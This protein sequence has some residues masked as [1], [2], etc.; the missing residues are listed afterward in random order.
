MGATSAQT[1]TS[2]RS[3]PAAAQGQQKPPGDHLLQLHLHIL[4]LHHHH[5]AP[6]SSHWV[7]LW[8]SDLHS[9]LMEEIRKGVSLKRVEVDVDVDVDE[10]KDV[11][12]GMYA[13]E[14]TTPGMLQGALLQR[15]LAVG[16]FTSGEL[17]EEENEWDDF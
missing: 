9:S 11:D 4:H 10:D 8:L 3:P 17:E 5:Q 14:A 16:M 13:V 1:E 15:R 6:P 12:E 2:H 7:N